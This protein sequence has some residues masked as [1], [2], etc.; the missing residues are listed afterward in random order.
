MP[1]SDCWQIILAPRKRVWTQVSSFNFPNIWMQRNVSTAAELKNVA[2]PFFAQRFRVLEAQK[3]CAKTSGPV[4]RASF[5]LIS[6]CS[7]TFRT[8]SNQ[9]ML[10]F[11]FLRNV[12]VNR[13]PKK[14]AQMCLDPRITPYIWLNSSTSLGSFIIFPEEMVIHQGFLASLRCQKNIFLQKRPFSIWAFK[15]ASF[16]KKYFSIKFHSYSLIVIKKTASGCL[17]PYEPR[18]LR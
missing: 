12:F 8:P 1:F 17:F 4:N 18:R 13:E 11:R 7:A 10:R 5:F 9:K 15:A 2:I 6:G 14:I 3:S 16:S